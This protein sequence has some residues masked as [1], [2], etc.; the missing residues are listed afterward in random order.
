MQQTRPAFGHAAT[1]G[2]AHPCRHGGPQHAEPCRPELCALRLVRATGPWVHHG[3][4]VRLQ[5][6]GAAGQVNV[7][8]H[9]HLTLLQDGAQVLNEGPL[10]QRRCKMRRT[11]GGQYVWSYG[12][13]DPLQMSHGPEQLSETAVMDYAVDRSESKGVLRV[14]GIGGVAGSRRKAP[15]RVTAQ[16]GRPPGLIPPAPAQLCRPANEHLLPAHAPPFNEWPD[17]SP[18]GRQGPHHASPKT[19]PQPLGKLGA[20]HGGCVADGL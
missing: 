5:E 6:L 11:G 12:Y 15:P 9:I 14:E 8:I 19:Q 1:R 18:S 4:G 17:Q 7:P 2:R 3:A 10:H 13:C 16:H 20:S